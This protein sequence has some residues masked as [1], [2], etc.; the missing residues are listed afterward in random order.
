MEINT[1]LVIQATVSLLFD[2][3]PTFL[4]DSSGWISDVSIVD[5]RVCA[6]CYCSSM[7]LHMQPYANAVISQ[8]EL[9]PIL[10]PIAPRPLPPLTASARLE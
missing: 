10:F 3:M 2:F 9:C 4:M 7:L 5:V 6:R 8:V 1:I